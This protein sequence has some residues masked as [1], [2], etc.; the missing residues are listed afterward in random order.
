MSVIDMNVSEKGEDLWGN[1]A[2]LT[3]Y[4]FLICL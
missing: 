2:H 4:R 3:H 1:H